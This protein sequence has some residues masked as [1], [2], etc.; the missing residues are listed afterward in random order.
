[1]AQSWWQCFNPSQQIRSHQTSR[2]ACPGSI[3]GFNPSQ[4]IRSHQTDARRKGSR[5]VRGVS[6]PLNKSGLIKRMSCTLIGHVPSFNPSQQIRSHQTAKE[7]IVLG[8]LKGFNPSQQIRS[9]QTCSCNDSVRH[10]NVR[11]QSLSTNQV[12]SNIP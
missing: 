9:H 1:M 10:R 3:S 8:K 7:H 5:P 2:S 4:Q 11:F 12:S 6:I